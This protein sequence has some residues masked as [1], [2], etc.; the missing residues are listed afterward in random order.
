MRHVVI[1]WL[2][3]A[4]SLAQEKHGYT[5]GTT[6]VTNSWLEGRIYDLEPNTRKLP[7][8]DGRKPV[9]KIYANML[10]VWPQRFDEGFPGI[11]D[12]FEW[13]A[14]DYSGKFWVELPGEYRFSLLS[15]DGAQLE[16]DKKLVVDNSS[17]HAPTA[18]SGS[19]VLS[20]GVH[21]IRVSYFQG[22]R[23]QV[24]LQVWVTPPAGGEKL[25]TSSF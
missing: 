8:L 25:L 13:F 1:L 21:T 7:D 20:R 10:N 18:I 22:P 19:A 4:A 11:T 23:F 3:A 12:R 5:F 14:I 24:A 2:A 16:V 17:L 6:V 9:G 15:D